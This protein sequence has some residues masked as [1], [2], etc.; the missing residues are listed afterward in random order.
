ME[1]TSQPGLQLINSLSA[2]VNFL[3]SEG[4]LAAGAL[5]AL[6]GRGDGSV[7]C[8]DASGIRQR[9]VAL[10]DASWTGVAACRR[11]TPP[12]PP[13]S[14]AP[15]VAEETLLREIENRYPA[16]DAASPRHISASPASTSSGAAAAA[17]SGGSVTATP[18]AR[19]RQSRSSGA[20]PG[21]G[22]AEPSGDTVD[23]QPALAAA[24]TLTPV[25]SMESAEK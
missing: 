25:D 8:R 2:V 4:F 20:A 3:H 13:P 16:P 15:P 19:R 12:A 9:A 24:H 5:V 14:P 1:D 23:F 11:P 17:A 18:A 22:S 21:S 7:D 6:A 10:L